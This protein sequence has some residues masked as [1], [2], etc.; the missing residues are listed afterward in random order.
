MGLEGSACIASEG[1]SSVAELPTVPTVPTVPIVPD[2]IADRRAAIAPRVSRQTS[3]DTFCRKLKLH[4]SQRRDE[5][6]SQAHAGQPDLVQCSKGTEICNSLEQ[7]WMVNSSDAFRL[8]FRFRFR[9]CC[10][11][12]RNH[13]SAERPWHKRA[14]KRNRVATGSSPSGASQKQMRSR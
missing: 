10:W 6:T 8:P 5:L 13:N 1:T 11:L 4:C 9:R 7:G 12:R 14:Y 3:H 2:S